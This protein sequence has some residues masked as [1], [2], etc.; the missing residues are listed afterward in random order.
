METSSK[1]RKFHTENAWLV[2]NAT[3]FTICAAAVYTIAM[4]TRPRLPTLVMW[5]DMTLVAINVTG[6]MSTSLSRLMNDAGDRTNMYRG[7]HHSLRLATL[8]KCQRLAADNVTI[9]RAS[10]V[11]SSR[12]GN[13]DECRSIT[14]KTRVQQCLWEII[15]ECTCRIQTRKNQLVVVVTGTGQNNVR[16]RLNVSKVDALCVLKCHH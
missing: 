7:Y 15:A 2:L 10:V 3:T 8:C 12:R 16:T 4:A 5:N 6:Q 13:Y 14:I 9:D 1:E 11:T